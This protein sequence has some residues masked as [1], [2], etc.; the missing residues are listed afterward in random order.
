MLKGKSSSN[1][2]ISRIALFT[3]IGALFLATAAAGTNAAGFSFMDS[4]KGFFGLATTQTSA[5]TIRP[6]ALNSPSA[7]ESMSPTAAFV[8]GN[9]AVVQIGDGTVAL[10]VN[11]APTSV[12]EYTTAGAL[13]QTIALPSAATSPRLTVAGSSTSEGHIVRSSDGNF[14]TLTGYDIAANTVPPF[15]VAGTA[16]TIARLNSAGTVDLTTALT[17]G[18][19]GSVRSAASTNGTDIWQTNSVVGLRYA[20]FGSTTST[21]VTTAPTNTRVVKVF[22]GQLYMT[23]GSATF[24]CT[25]SV[26]TLTPTT[27]GNTTTPFPGMVCSGRSP[28][29]FSTR[30]G[31]WPCGRRDARHHRRSGRLCHANRATWHWPRGHDGRIC[32]PGLRPPARHL[33]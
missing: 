21:Q 3:V 15:A 16:R 33:W 32:G 28:Y 2:F 13:V 31:H 9:L 29:S 14:L 23:S 10:T 26:G 18:S 1:S 25:N 4:V 24:T 7:V 27:T 6:E 19:T 30:R 17:D 5:L 8:P 11:S 12:V 22:N 20:T